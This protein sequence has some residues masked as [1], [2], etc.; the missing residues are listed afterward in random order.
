MCIRDSTQRVRLGP[1]AARIFCSDDKIS[2]VGHVGG[3]H[4]PG[5]LMVTNGRGKN[6]LGMGRGHERGKN[7]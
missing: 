7:L 6:P 3:N 4:I 1:G 2:L 5:A